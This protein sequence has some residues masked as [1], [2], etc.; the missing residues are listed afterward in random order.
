MLFEM[1]Q[2]G[3]VKGDENLRIL[4]SFSQLI[5]P[6]HYVK[7]HPRIARIT[8]ISQEDLMEANRSLLAELLEQ[9]SLEREKRSKEET[10]L[11]RDQVMDML[12]ISPTTLWRW[13]KQKYLVPIEIGAKR[14]YLRSEVERLLKH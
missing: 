4:D 10:Y 6:T 1:I 11:T 14:L 3:A 12:N 8:H 9:E 7:L 2:I 5:R 13:M